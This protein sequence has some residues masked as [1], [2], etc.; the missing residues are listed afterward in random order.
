MILCIGTTP[1]LQR[2]M[3]FQRLRLRSV[4]RAV[5]VLEGIAG[6]SVNVAK[7]LRTLGG[8]P[9]AVGFC[10]GVRGGM[11]CGG[12]KAAGIAH[13]FVT[14]TTPTRECVTVIDETAATQTELVE[15]S[16][17]ASA[18]AFARLETVIRRRVKDC[19]AV[20]MSGSIAPGGPPDFYARCVRWA[21]QAGTLSIV[22]AQGPPLIGALAAKPGLIKPNV[23]ELAATVK[24]TLPN[25]TAVLEAMFELCGRGAERVVVTCGGKPVLACDGSRCWKITPPSVRVLNPIGSGDAFTAGIAWRLVHGD[26]LGEACRWGAAAGSA[27]ALSYMPGELSRKDVFRLARET[28][29]ER[30]GFRR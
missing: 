20:V 13:D 7:V 4:N 1:A 12:L 28:R 24:R 11:L 3:V 6:K 26:D 19:R 16:R 2:V 29:V 21:G 30:I 18:A 5:S 15:E 22:D 10:G 9:L 8:S 14:V 27:N 17:P 25:Q 23:A